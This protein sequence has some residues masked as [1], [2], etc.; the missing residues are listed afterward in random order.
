MRLPATL[1]AGSCPTARVWETS[2]PLPACP[3]VRSQSPPLKKYYHQFIFVSR[4]VDTK[5]KISL[6][7]AIC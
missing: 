3:A 2:H 5:Y 4:V 6:L 1:S 7:D